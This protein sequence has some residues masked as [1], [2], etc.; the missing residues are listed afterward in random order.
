MGPIEII[1]EK[2]AISYLNFGRTSTCASKITPLLKEAKAQ[3]DSYFNHQP[4]QFNLP[5]TPAATVFQEKMRAY[6]LAIPPGETRSYGEAANFLTSA[7]RSTGQ[8]CKRNPIPIIVPCHRIIAADGRLGGYSGSG[9][10]QTKRFLLTLENGRG[11]W[12]S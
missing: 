11:T 9:G 5:L 7:P 8:A 1:E 10:R 4:A 2:G 6:M 12:S 3:L